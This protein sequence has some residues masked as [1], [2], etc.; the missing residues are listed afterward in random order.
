MREDNRGDNDPNYPDQTPTTDP[1]RPSWLPPG[2]VLN[3]DGSV[4][5]PNGTVVPGPPPGYSR[6]PNTGVIG[7]DGGVVSGGP[8]GTTPPMVQ[9]TDPNHPQTDPTNPDVVINPVLQSQY[10]P[11]TG[12]TPTSPTHVVDPGTVGGGGGGGGSATAPPAMPSPT[13]S[14]SPY[15]GMNIGDFTSPFT[16]KFTAPDPKAIPDAP[17][18]K[19]PDFKTPDPFKAPTPEEAMNDPGYKFT[20]GQGIGALLNSRAA[21]GMLNS[22]ATG[23]ALVDYGQAAGS[24]QYGNV[25]NRDLGNYMTNYKT[26]YVDPYQNAYQNAQGEFAPKLTAWQTTAPMIQ[27]QNN[28]DYANSFNKWLTDYNMFTGTQDRGFDKFLKVLG[29]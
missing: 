3:A 29:S 25:Y 5:M 15:F 9:G 21:G 23:K 11:G 14:G 18:F 16:E 4:T 2:A 12:G 10:A 13:A 22:G 8:T 1:N 26:Q 20:L 7:Y 24:T 28:T 6:D 19:A 27:A 17:V